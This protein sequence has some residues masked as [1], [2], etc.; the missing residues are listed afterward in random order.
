MKNVSE[1]NAL[2]LKYTVLG[3]IVYGFESLKRLVE[4]LSRKV[5]QG[6]GIQSIG[7]YHFGKY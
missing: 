4:S 3:K 5:S 6:S 7:V 1:L 2:Q